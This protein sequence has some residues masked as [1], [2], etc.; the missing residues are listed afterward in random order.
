[1]NTK[2]T[3]S[4][5][6]AGI[7][8]SVGLA[9]SGMTMPTKV[10]GF[11]NIFG[12]WDPALMGVMGGGILVAFFAFRRLR[13]WEHPL[14]ANNFHIPDRTDITSSLVV[15]S[16]IFG[17]GWGIL[18]Y[19]PGPAVASIVTGYTEV[20]VFVAAMLGGMLAHRLLSPLWTKQ[21]PEYTSETSADA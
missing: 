14:F 21:G 13:L 5:F 7:L 6:V 16:A 12:E 19:C 15:G 3:L 17:V 11:L 18:G 10:V 9:V 4:A 8:F 20:L 1:M 2:I